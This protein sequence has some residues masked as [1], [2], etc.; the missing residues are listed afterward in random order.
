MPR[1]AITSTYK[2]ANNN[3]KKS[4]DIKGKQI[5]ENLDKEILDRMDF[6]SKNACFISSKGPKRGLFE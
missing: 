6:N 4:I 2:K 3:I 1:S 5:M